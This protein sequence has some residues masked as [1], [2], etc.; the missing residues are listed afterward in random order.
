[1]QYQIRNNSFLPPSRVAEMTRL[2]KMGYAMVSYW[3]YVP[4]NLPTRA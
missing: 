4:I 2:L 3:Y 1:M